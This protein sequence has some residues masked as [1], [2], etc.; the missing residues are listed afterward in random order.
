MVSRGL[1]GIWVADVN[2]AER[3]G[4]FRGDPGESYEHPESW[5]VGRPRVRPRD[6]LTQTITRTAQAARPNRFVLREGCDL[7]TAAPQVRA[8]WLELIDIATTK[9][10][11]LADAALHAE[12]HAEGA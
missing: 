3:P 2:L 11:G 6:W 5:F 12:V 9:I 8:A 4:V 10:A 7:W 1:G